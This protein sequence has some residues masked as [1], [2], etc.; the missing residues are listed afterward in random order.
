MIGRMK[1]REIRDRFMKRMVA[2][3]VFEITGLW[4]HRGGEFVDTRYH[5]RFNDGTEVRDVVSV[6]PE[7]PFGLYSCADV[8]ARKIDPGCFFGEC[9]LGCFFFR[10]G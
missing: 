3:S 9:L 10:S 2:G 4:V 1:E 8:A 7:F 6:F 5:L